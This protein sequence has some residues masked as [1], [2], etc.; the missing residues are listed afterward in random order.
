[1]ASRNYLIVSED[2]TL[3]DKKD[4]RLNALAAG[5]ERCGLKSIGDINADVP[6]LQAVPLDNKPGRVALIKNFIMTGKWPKSIDQRELRP[7]LT[8]TVEDL[9][10][11]PVLNSWLTAPMAAVG[12]FYSCFQALAT[13][14]LLQGKLLVCWGVSVDS[15]A[16][17]LPVS[18]LQFLKGTNIQAMF[19]M[20]AMMVR[21]EVDAFLSEPVVF[22]PTDTF[23]IQ[24]RCRNATA[25]AEIVHIHNF[26][27][28]SSGLVIA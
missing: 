8:G 3:S 25:V 19:D 2:M 11:P 26:L 9:V 13:P 23:A 10:V 14:Q 5:L 18:R 4:Y 20:E 15:A 27:F 24:V 6:G 28:E 12:A 16:V 1:M 7:G 22:D 21:D 17:P